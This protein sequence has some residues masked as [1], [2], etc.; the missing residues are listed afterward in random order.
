MILVIHELDHQL[1]GSSPQHGLVVAM[2]SSAA[3]R[4]NARE[5]RSVTAFV[6]D[7]SEWFVDE[8]WREHV[9]PRHWRRL[10]ARASVSVRLVLQQL[11]DR[12][13]R[14]TFFVPAAL[15][16]SA[17]ELLCDLVAAGHEV[18]LSVRSPWPID[19]VPEAKR[20][21]FVRAWE[22]ER[23]ELER[24]IG[25]AVHGFSSCWSV[26]AGDAWWHAPLRVLGFDYDAT[27][28][29]GSESVA[30]GLQDEVVGEVV[31]GRRFLAWQIDSE[32]PRLAG[33]PRAV[34]TA[35]ESALRG[36]SNLL[37]K[38]CSDAD[39]TIAQ[40]LRLDRRAPA[41]VPLPPDDVGIA[42]T[43]GEHDLISRDRHHKNEVPRLAIIVPLKD[44]AEG[45]Q[46]LFLELIAIKAALS[47]VVVCEFVLVD[48]GSTDETWLLLEKIA[49]AYL[50]VR[51]V[52]HAQ[53]RGVA[54]AIRTGFFATDADWVASID[55]DL[56]YDPMELRQMLQ[57]LPDA[58]VVTASPYH[59]EGGVL[60]VPGWR[61]FLSRTLSLAYRVLLGSRISTWTS[62]F[63]VYR[64]AFVVNLPLKNG[65]FLGTAELLVRVLRRGG[66]VVEHPCVLEARLLGFSKMRVFD[67]VLDHMRLL[68]L[69]ALRLVK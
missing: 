37:A 60:N 17:P 26:A 43:N 24:V 31:S 59:A 25:T 58:D 4:Y 12:G 51:L 20:D 6:I 30:I 27:R 11:Q 1:G 48:D 64:R 21:A 13:V 69:V 10:P 33:L 38:L 35:H 49:R 52:R 5:S 54:A 19:Q 9:T 14:A 41:P 3:T 61:L 32:Q 2:V 65:G 44:E 23:A 16:F 68:V 36:G 15:A 63:R 67:V 22:D 50:D 18:A 29:K 66:R 53:N 55:G 40:S 56:S 8:E 42:G 45:V 46:S 34:R 28:V 47:D 62:C 39:G 7:A 57:H